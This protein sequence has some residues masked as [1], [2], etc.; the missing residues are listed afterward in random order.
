LS[1]NRSRTSFIARKEA[2]S[3]SHAYHQP[4]S[5]LCLLTVPC[6]VG[7][8]VGLP[9]RSSPRIVDLTLVMG[10]TLLPTKPFRFL[11]VRP[12]PNQFSFSCLLSSSIFPCASSPDWIEH[13]TDRHC[14]IRPTVSVTWE[15]ELSL[16]LAAGGELND[17][18]A[19]SCAG[20]LT[21]DKF[22][23]ARDLPPEVMLPSKVLL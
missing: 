16:G 18:K 5:S 20:L 9:S 13:N 8:G 21:T 15:E 11:P 12:R 23:A 17:W 7:V 14:S 19:T 3:L 1:T 10:L 4:A 22:D 2:M 6:L